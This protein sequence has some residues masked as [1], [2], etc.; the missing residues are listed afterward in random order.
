MLS[1]SLLFL[2]PRTIALSS[3]MLFL[4]SPSVHLQSLYLP[5]TVNI[6]NLL[7]NLV[8]EVVLKLLGR[9]HAKQ[10]RTHEDE[11]EK[12]RRRAKVG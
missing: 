12:E 1:D 9:H 8:D 3:S 6:C 2:S 10:K 7:D 4:W 5:L 11:T